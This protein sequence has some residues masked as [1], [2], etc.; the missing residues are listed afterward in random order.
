MFGFGQL[1]CVQHGLVFWMFAALPA[2][3]VLLAGK[4]EPPSKIMLQVH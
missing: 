4:Q 2:C 1:S 3:F